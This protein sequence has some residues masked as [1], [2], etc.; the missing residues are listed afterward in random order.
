MLDPQD[1]G[2]V[3][4]F[5]A[6]KTDEEIKAE[7]GVD[8]AKLTQLRGVDQE[9]VKEEVEGEEGTDAPV[10]EG[11]GEEVVEDAPVEA[12]ED[13]P[14]GEAKPEGEDKAGEVA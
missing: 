14:E 2:I 13:A 9:E 10:E 4:A 12:G 1:Q 7:F 6:G 11:T 3:D 5:K 8:D